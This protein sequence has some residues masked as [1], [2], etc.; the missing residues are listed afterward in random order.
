MKVVVATLERHFVKNL[1]LSNLKLNLKSDVATFLLQYFQKCKK[2]GQK[3]AML[4]KKWEKY[5]LSLFHFVL[6]TVV[7]QLVQTPPPHCK[8]CLGISLHANHIRSRYL[9]GFLS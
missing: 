2:V 6:V 8:L 5:L 1:Q 4:Q 7:V 3:S 9:F